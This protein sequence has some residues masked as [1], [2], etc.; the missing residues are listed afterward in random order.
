MLEIGDRV[1][2]NADSGEAATLLSSFG[3][4]W[5]MAADLVIGK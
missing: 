1:L 5:M 3:G 4:R 2:L